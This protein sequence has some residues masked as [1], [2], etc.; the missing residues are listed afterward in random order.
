[1]R[2]WTPTQ[3]V[4]LL[5]VTPDIDGWSAIISG[6]V[7]CSGA[8]VPS[9]TAGNEW[10]ATASRDASVGAVALA[11]TDPAGYTVQLVQ[12]AAQPHIAGAGRGLGA[13]GTAAASTFA[14]EAE[15]SPPA[16]PETIFVRLAGGGSNGAIDPIA[17]ALSCSVAGFVLGCCAKRAMGR[18]KTGTGNYKPIEMDRDS[19]AE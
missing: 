10:G 18:S 3:A 4:S 1:M 2:Q 12:Q 5:L 15:A 14:Q 8:L 11:C 7:G 13:S 9:E 17:L 19:A 6:L 16:Q